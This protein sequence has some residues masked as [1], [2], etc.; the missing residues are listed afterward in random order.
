MTILPSLITSAH[1]QP[2]DDIENLLEL[3][4]DEKGNWLTPPIAQLKMIND[5]ASRLFSKLTTFDPS[6]ITKLVDEVLQKNIQLG[7]ELK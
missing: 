4:F 6:K 7:G 1:F 3:R 2:S 5:S